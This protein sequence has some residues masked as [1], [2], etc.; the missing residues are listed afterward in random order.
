ME[1]RIVVFLLIFF[2]A[3]IA[4]ILILNYQKNSE[5]EIIYD[6]PLEDQESRAK[7][8]NS[9]PIDLR[10]KELTY[11]EKIW[12]KIIDDSFKPVDCPVTTRN[13]DD[14]Y[15][16]GPL[17]DTHIHIAPIPDDVSN[18]IDYDEISPLM[19]VNIKMTDY[20]CMMDYE[21]TSKVFAF[22]PVWEPITEQF[23][24]IVNRTKQEYPDRFMPFIMPPDH[25]DRPDG[26]PTLK[27]EELSTETLQK[28]RL[29]IQL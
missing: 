27:A 11:E 20:V 16:K 23:L 17:I 15:Y 29:S 12:K 14:S 4:V 21:N 9:T 22:F 13:L 18:E 24:E 5:N 28:L 8:A 6:N 26:Y 25:D 3:I 1:K 10:Q 2:V 19:G 7:H